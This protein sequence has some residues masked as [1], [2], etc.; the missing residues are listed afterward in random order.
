MKLCAVEF[1]NLLLAVLCS[2][3][4]KKCA[5]TWQHGIYFEGHPLCLDYTPQLLG[6]NTEAQ[7][8]R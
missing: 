4:G 5:V 3:G 6:L 2:E 8:H 7:I 1:L